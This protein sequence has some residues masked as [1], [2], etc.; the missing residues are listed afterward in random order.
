MKKQLNG[1]TDDMGRVFWLPGRVGFPGTV[2]AIFILSIHFHSCSLVNKLLNY[3]SS[4]RRT[5]QKAG[6]RLD[7][8]RSESGYGTM[9][10][11]P[12]PPPPPC[13]PRQLS[14]PSWINNDLFDPLHQHSLTWLMGKSCVCVFLLVN[15]LMKCCPWKGHTCQQGH[16]F[17]CW[18]SCVLK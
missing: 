15:T 6:E 7:E 18:N 2:R 4:L 3:S 17:R 16:N 13:L 9:E 1:N 8:T 5:E 10:T 12:P 11:P 14:L